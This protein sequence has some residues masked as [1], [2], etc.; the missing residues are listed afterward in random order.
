MPNALKDQ[1]A[2]ITGASRGIGKAIAVRLAKQ[3]VSVALVSRNVEA[4]KETAQV[5]SEFGNPVLTLPCDLANTGSIQN[6]VS[7]TTAKLGGLNILVNNAGV[8]I[9]DPADSGELEDWDLTIDINLRAL[10]HLTRHAL[11]EI[12]KASRGAVIN[13][14][15]MAGR[16]PFGGASAYCATK[17]GVVGFS[18]ALFEDVRERN[19]K[20][21]AVCPGYVATEM[22]SEMGLA[23]E[24][25][26]Q[27]DG[28]AK[29]VEFVLTYPDN[30][31][32][33][34]I[35]IMPQRSPYSS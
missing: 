35:Q 22:T 15:S 13:I 29:A 33:I 28:V 17:H 23:V 26:I 11:P 21:S 14:A 32:P 18:H 9:T 7:Q 19:I 5:C 27:A 4:L 3:G 8:A 2:L 25:M 24:K 16:R 12:E 10:M 6:L 31:C 30:A 20:V 1:V 34:E